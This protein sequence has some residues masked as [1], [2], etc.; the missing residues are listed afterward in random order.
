M[1]NNIVSTIQSVVTRAA[2]EIAAAVR[3]DIARQVQGLVG[4][5]GATPKRR[6]RPPGKAA[7]QPG[8]AAP[9]K[10]GPKRGW[11]RRLITDAELNAVLSVLAKKPGLT[12]V[13]IQKEARIDAK[14]AARVLN[15]LRETR[16][17]K[18]KGQRSAATY[19]A[20]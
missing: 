9:G 4:A 10:R 17:V 11:K 14:Q 18:W 16:K 8:A 3:A 7:A 6:G 2:S 15:K 19:R 1:P 13:Q 12:S 5:A 20:A